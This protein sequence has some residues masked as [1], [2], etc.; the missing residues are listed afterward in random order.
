MKRCPLCKADLKGADLCRRCGADLSSACKAAEAARRHYRAAREAF[1][2]GD[3]KTMLAHAEQ[4]ISKRRVPE[5]RRLLACAA[6]LCGDHNLALNIWRR[7][8]A[9]KNQAP[10]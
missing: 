8:G 5:T 9:S 10:F 6:M 1:L 7:L 4:A 2:Q 3:S